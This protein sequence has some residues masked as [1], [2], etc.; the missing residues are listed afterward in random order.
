[1]LKLKSIAEGVKD[2]S[3]RGFLIQQGC[4][5]VQGYLVEK[6]NKISIG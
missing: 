3:Q 1:M 2:T 5:N 4:G 6:N